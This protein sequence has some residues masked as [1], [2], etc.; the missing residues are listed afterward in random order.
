MAKEKIKNHE[1]LNMFAKAQALSDEDRNAIKTI[2]KAF[3][4]QKDIL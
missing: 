4:F 2:Q 1:L 3:I